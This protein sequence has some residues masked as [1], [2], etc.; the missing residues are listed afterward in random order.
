VKRS[1]VVALAVSAVLNAALLV[2]YRG[3]W[4]HTVLA[5]VIALWIGGFAFVLA[6]AFY[7]LGSGRPA[8]RRAAPVIAIVGIVAVSGLLSVVP[9]RW[10]AAYDVEAAKR[11]AQSIIPQL[12]TYK[13]AN[14]RYPADLSGVRFDPNAPRLV[15]DSNSVWY[16]SDG[17][18]FQIDLV[19][20]RGLLNHIGYDSETRTWREWH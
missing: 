11:F 16:W 9:G 8:W 1:V 10:R 3:D 15:R 2:P 6:A 18:Q 19:D 4:T 13:R 14:G 5:I 12:E 17:V 20:P 7:L